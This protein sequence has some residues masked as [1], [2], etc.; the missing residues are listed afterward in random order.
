[1]TWKF[2]ENIANN[3][4]DNTPLEVTPR[5]TIT[6]E[7]LKKLRQQNGAQDM[8]SPMEK[9]ASGRRERS[10][11][12]VQDT[13]DVFLSEEEALNLLKNSNL[14]LED[15]GQEI[16]MR[17][18]IKGKK[19][20]IFDISNYQNTHGTIDG[21][22]LTTDE[23]NEIVTKYLKVALAH[24]IDKTDSQA[25]NSEEGKKSAALGDIL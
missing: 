21:V 19:I 17:G 6:P 3:L 12:S 10:I 16:N 18:T 15:T 9:E 25:I 23:A 7:L 2:I 13:P 11:L 24:E 22:P 1:M 4:V 14:T 8:M 20:E 5:L